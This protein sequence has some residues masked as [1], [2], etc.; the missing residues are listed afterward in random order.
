MNELESLDIEFDELDNDGAESY[1]TE[2]AK[3]LP[4]M[5]ASCCGCHFSCCCDPILEP[6][7]A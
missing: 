5:S 7:E 6:V 2:S 3:G 4:E 1:G